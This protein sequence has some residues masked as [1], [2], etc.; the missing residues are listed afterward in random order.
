ME[1]LRDFSVADAARALGVSD[2]RVR[3]LI[4]ASALAAQQVGGRWLVSRAD[5]EQ[6]ARRSG[7]PGRPL[8]QRNAWAL[9][10]RLSGGEWPEL[11]P[12]DRSRLKRRLAKQSLLSLADDLRDRAEPHLFRGD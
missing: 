3:A 6:R 9:V 5:V 7:R 1:Q 10:A 2:R 12:W 4:R 8:G 11:S